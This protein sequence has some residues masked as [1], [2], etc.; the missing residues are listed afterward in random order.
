M[1]GAASCTCTID[2]R[3]RRNPPRRVVLSPL[4]CHDST[5]TDDEILQAVR[6]NLSAAIIDGTAAII[7]ATLLPLI[8]LNPLDALSLATCYPFDTAASA[9]QMAT[10]QSNC[11]LVV[12]AGWRGAKVDDNRLSMPYGVRCTRGGT[13]YAVT[14]EGVIA[15]EHG[16]LVGGLPWVEGTPFPEPGDALTVGSQSDPSFSRGGGYGGEHEFTAIHWGPSD[17]LDGDVLTSIDGGQP[18]IRFRTRALVEV[19][20]GALPDGRRKGELW[21]ANLDASGR[22]VLGADGRP[23]AGRRVVH[24]ADASKLR[25]TA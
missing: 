22:Y 25:V 19:W 6:D 14:L 17:V 3:M 23:M 10:K 12:E 15:A 1:G 9:K 21:A 16:A 7:I 5:M 11:G 20:T 13:L 8:G 18:G 4:S 24:F 2:S